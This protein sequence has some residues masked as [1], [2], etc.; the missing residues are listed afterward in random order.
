MTSGYEPR[1]A[2]S[3]HKFARMGDCGH[4]MN[5]LFEHLGSVADDLT[6]VRS[7]HTEPIN[8]DPAVTFIQTGSGVEPERYHSAVPVI[9][10][11]R[12]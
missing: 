10:C 7:L 2:Q 8:H 6:I 1:I 5:V 11:R 3:E 9:T 4:E 12:R